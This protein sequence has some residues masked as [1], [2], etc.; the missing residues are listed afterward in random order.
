[1]SFDS[2]GT[3][4]PSVFPEPKSDPITRLNPPGTPPPPAPRRRT[5][6]QVG[7]APKRP[8]SH[9]C[10]WPPPTRLH[11]RPPSHRPHP[12]A[13][14]LCTGG[15]SYLVCLTDPSSLPFSTCWNTGVLVSFLE[16]LPPS[17]PWASLSP[18][19]TAAVPL[20]SLSTSCRRE[21]VLGDG[22]ACC[23]QGLA[24][25]VREGPTGPPPASQVQLPLVLRTMNLAFVVYSIFLDLTLAGLLPVFSRACL[26]PR[27]CQTPRSWPITEV[28]PGQ[29]CLLSVGPRPPPSSRETSSGWR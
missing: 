4:E 23:G 8:C 9:L 25:S 3:L 20:C 19:R 22:P 18:P 7:V 24:V 26:V 11:L 17:S 21:W 29:G 14:G 10:S 16:P 12:M 13:L 6:E 27:V 1:M 5:S 28:R 15:L 2:T